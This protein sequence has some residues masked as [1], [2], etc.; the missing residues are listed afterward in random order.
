MPNA[1]GSISNMGTIDRCFDLLGIRALEMAMAALE[2]AWGPSL[3]PQRG[4]IIQVIGKI[5]GFQLKER[6][7]WADIEVPVR[8]TLRMAESDRL[9]RIINFSYICGCPDHVVGYYQAAGFKDVQKVMDIFDVDTCP[10]AD[11]M[12]KAWETA[13]LEVRPHFMLITAA[14]AEAGKNDGW[15]TSAANAFERIETLYAELATSPVP[16]PDEPAADPDR[17]PTQHAPAPGAAAEAAPAARPAGL[18]TTPLDD[19]LIKLMVDAADGTQ[20]AKTPEEID[21]IIREFSALNSSRFQSKFHRGFFAALFGKS[22]PPRAGSAE[23]DERRAWLLAGW[24]LG[25]LRDSSRGVP[26]E[27]DQLGEDDQR[28][29]LSERG[30][31]AAEQIADEVVRRLTRTGDTGAIH[32][33]LRFVSPPGAHEALRH[34][35]QLLRDGRPAEADKLARCLLGFVPNAAAGRNTVS[36]IDLAAMTVAATSARMLGNFDMAL[37]HLDPVAQVAA[38]IVRDMPTKPVPESLLNTLADADAQN[39]L[40]TAR[41]KDV[42][43][44]WFSMNPADQALR[45][46]LLPIGEVLLEHARTK[47]AHRSGTLCYCAALWIL[48]NPKDSACLAAAAPCIESLGILIAEIQSDDAPRLT[49]SLLPRLLALRALLT[50]HAGTGNVAAAVKD[51]NSFEASHGRLPF[52][53]VRGSIESGIAADAGGV[54]DL[55]LSRIDHDLQN[56]IRSDLLEAIATHPRVGQAVFDN[57]RAYTRNLSRADAALVASTVFAASVDAGASREQMGELA[58]EMVA[59]TNDYSGAAAT[60]LGT[61][62]ERDR[63]TYVW[64]ELEFTGIRARLAEA[65]PESMR[66]DTARWLVDRA[67]RLAFHEVELANECL[68]LAEWL[69]SPHEAGARVRA[70]IERTHN[71]GRSEG[72]SPRT[73]AEAVTV[74]FVGGDERQSRMQQDIRRLVDGSRSHVRILFHH[75][76]WGSNWAPTID[77]IGRELRSVDI[78][79]L[80]PFVRTTFGHHLRRVI[81]DAGKQWRPTYGH[82]APSIAR[83]IV[84]AANDASLKA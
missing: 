80:N 1:V 9:A 27:L 65:L 36:D 3:H 39:I 34:A 60:C 78:V 69:G 38:Q 73:G 67:H 81:N 37:M 59:I 74:M 84:G 68:A 40:C 6:S 13:S 72:G 64:T 71:A 30:R 21:A 22:L 7:P 8:R 24:L 2:S 75:P 56:F 16:A 31:D 32:R 19:V 46:Q 11:A 25:R 82:A 57:F 61:F 4:R 62:L 70:V 12:V 54:E 42:S 17:E 18:R 52:H 10:D 53:V 49:R 51:I 41:I 55:V 14:I 47:G 23:N 28:T 20:F 29:L 26:A 44:L 48:C 5:P 79:V 33:W 35:K 63:W 43:T 50:L 77:A 45:Q 76:G 58:D 15:R 66:P 83:A